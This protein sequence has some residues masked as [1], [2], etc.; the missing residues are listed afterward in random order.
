MAEAFPLTWPAGW[1]RTG[2]RKKSLFAVSTVGAASAKVFHELKLLGTTRVVVSTNLRLR[3]DGLPYSD[4]SQPEDGGVA[5]YFVYKDKQ[6]CFACD[7]YRR[8]QE[9]IIA[10]AKTIEALR[11]MERWGASQM[12]ERAFSGFAALPAK[13]EDRHWSTVLGLTRGASPAQIDARYK[14]LARQANVDFGQGA[15]IVLKELNVARDQ[16]KRD[17]LS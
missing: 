8:I 10:I 5:V 11:G 3:R 14:E 2:Q 4:Q 6:M 17:V 7:T 9:N 16:A 15:E 12:M 1:K 13:T